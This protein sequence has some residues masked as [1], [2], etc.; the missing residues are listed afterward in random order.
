LR[1]ELGTTVDKS[2]VKPWFAA[3]FAWFFLE[4]GNLKFWISAKQE[5]GILVFFFVELGI[6]LHGDDEFELV[7]GH[8]L[9]LA[10]EFVC[11]TKERNTE[12]EI[13]LFD[14]FL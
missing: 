13:R 10:F 9:K 8:A 11:V 14:D 4:I 2:R 6:L 1:I 12:I 5:L 7:M 3:I